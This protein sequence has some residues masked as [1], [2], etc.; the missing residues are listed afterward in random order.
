[1]KLCEQ[2]YTIRYMT[3]QDLETLIHWFESEKL[4]YYYEEN[5]PQNIL[6]KKYKDKI[7]G[8]SRVIGFILMIDNIEIGY[9]QIYP[10]STNIKKELN[11]NNSEKIY[12]IDQFIAEPINWGKGYGTTFIRLMI[13]FL[14]LEYNTDRVLL[15]VRKDNIRAIKSYKK[16]GFEYKI[17]KD[18][19]Y[20]Y[21]EHICSS[22]D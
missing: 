6:I 5:Q 19:K 3:E 2:L 17:D 21:M 12:G 15:D 7:K 4:T 10:I 20:I 22:T 16:C 14:S 9:M 18:D 1:M 8:N 11:Y 13:K